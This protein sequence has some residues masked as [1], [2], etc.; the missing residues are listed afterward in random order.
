M[1]FRWSEARI[2]HDSSEKKAHDAD[3][4]EEL[5]ISQ[6]APTI[7]TAQR[8]AIIV[9]GSLWSLGFMVFVLAYWRILTRPRVDGRPG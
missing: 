9:S 5:L 7:Q 6:L 3:W 8:E 2:I 1:A 4:Q